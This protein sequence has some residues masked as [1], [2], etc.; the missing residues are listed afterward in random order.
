MLEAASVSLR[1]RWADLTGIS[2][3]NFS[4]FSGHNFEGAIRLTVCLRFEY[5][6]NVF[7]LVAFAFQTSFAPLNTD[8]LTFAFDG[9]PTV[10]FTSQYK[11]RKK[12]RIGFPASKQYFL[13]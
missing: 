1:L 2:A 5:P 10:G 7:V 4:E 12:E 11:S 6:V 13:N 8:E 9:K 3:H